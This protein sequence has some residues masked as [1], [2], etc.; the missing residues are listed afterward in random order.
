MTDENERNADP[1]FGRFAVVCLLAGVAVAGVI[2]AVAQ[3][4]EFGAS[5]AAGVCGFFWLT[6]IVLAAV[7]YRHPWGKVAAWLAVV[8]PALILVAALFWLFASGA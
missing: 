4:L 1:S 5:I 3:D 7:G 8:P 2:L 6:G